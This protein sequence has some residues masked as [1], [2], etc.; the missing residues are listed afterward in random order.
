MLITKH[1]IKVEIREKDKNLF[2]NLNYLRK[3]KE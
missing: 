1:Q 3:K 2:Y